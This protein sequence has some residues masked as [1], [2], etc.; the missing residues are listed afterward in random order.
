MS[1][2][3]ATHYVCHSLHGCGSI[4]RD[5]IIS[6]RNLNCWAHENTNEEGECNF[7]HGFLVNMGCG[8]LGNNLIGPHVSEGFLTILYY[9]NF[10]DNEL[11]LNLAVQQ[12]D[13]SGYNT[14]EHLCILAGQ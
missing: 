6:T 5:D 2:T 14:M 3:M 4:N 11:R 8:L 7:Q 12:E 10:L 1:A 13:E 9:R